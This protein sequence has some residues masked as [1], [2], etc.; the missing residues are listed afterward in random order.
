MHR[1]TAP[2]FYDHSSL[3]EKVKI[4]SRIFSTWLFYSL[5]SLFLPDRKTFDVK[6]LVPQ[7]NFTK[8]CLNKDDLTSK[9]TRKIDDTTPPKTAK[10]TPGPLILTFREFNL[11]NRIF[12]IFEFFYQSISVLRDQNKYIYI[13]LRTLKVKKEESLRKCQ[14]VSCSSSHLESEKVTLQGAFWLKSSLSPGLAFPGGFVDS[15]SKRAI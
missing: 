11:H 6:F 2:L 12:T 5:N 7:T 1:V 15:F 8:F 9:Q 14:R 13:I 10:T 3:L 4:F